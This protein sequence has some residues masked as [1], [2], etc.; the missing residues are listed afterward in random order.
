MHG[1]SIKEKLLRCACLCHERVKFRQHSVR[2]GSSAITVLFLTR[3][4]D[5][6]LVSDVYIGDLFAVKGDEWVRILTCR[7]I[8]KAKLT[9]PILSPSPHHPFNVDSCHVRASY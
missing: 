4:G 5:C 3:E 2:I 6:E 9:F 8:T 7:V 1:I